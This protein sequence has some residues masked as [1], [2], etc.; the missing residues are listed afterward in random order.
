MSQAQIGSTAAKSVPRR[1]SHWLEEEIK[2]LIPP[3]IFFL[4]SFGLVLLI[5][6]LF[7]IN[8]DIQISV[9]TNAILGALIGAKVALILDK[10]ELGREAGWPPI[11]VVAFRTALYS[12]A[13]MLLGVLERIIEG[14]R[15]TGSLSGGVE[16][17][18]NNFVPGRF[19]ALVLLVT[20]V[21]GVFFAGREISKSL[22]D[23][24][25]YKLFFRRP[26]RHVAA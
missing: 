10:V 15:H 8:Y 20:M 11:A 2:A 5:V 13:F 17:W 26:S 3:V 6:K 7:L 25:L 12:V 19:F 18:L 1:F 21:F 9:L 23:G 22:G 24:G 14:T 4:I 16:H